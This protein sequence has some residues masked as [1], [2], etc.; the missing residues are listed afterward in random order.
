MTALDLMMLRT[1]FLKRMLDKVSTVLIG[2]GKIGIGYDFSDN[3]LIK[4][5]T[6]TH[7]KALMESQTFSVEAMVDSDLTVLD[8]FTNLTYIESGTSLSSLPN[9]KNFDLLVLACPTANHLQELKNSISTASFNYL[10]IEK[11]VGLNYFEC[12][13]IQDLTEIN[14]LEVY[15]N[16]FRRYLRT[17]GNVK[18]YLNSID[19]GTF[20]SA[21]IKSY[22][23][24][25]NIFSHFIDLSLE[26]TKS[27]VFCSCPKSLLT[28]NSSG[29]TVKCDYCVSQ[30]SLTG[31]DGSK[32][33]SEVIL[34]F[35][36]VKVRITN[37][38]FD[39]EVIDKYSHN[40]KEFKSTPYEI[41]NYQEIV[42]AEISTVLGTPNSF[43]GLAQAI[44]V[45]RFIESIY[46]A[47]D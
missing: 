18:A 24:L 47:H 28:R 8:R 26:I 41:R 42:Y 33:D 23:S 36:R 20:Q 14:N 12:L 29:V 16:Y 2:L 5:Q 39:F 37:N 31:I 32:C 15:V 21:T 4:D 27:C 3:G 43:S 34:N 35:E 17:T 40:F 10:V 1:G 19:K 25:H 46:S 7:L 30:I 11:P 22:G 45:H 9:I 6:F 38:G 13:E 44:S